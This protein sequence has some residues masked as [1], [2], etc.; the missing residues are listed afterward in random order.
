V[1]LLKRDESHETVKDDMY[2]ELDDDSED[3]RIE[4]V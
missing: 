2:E 4:E 3:E 1:N